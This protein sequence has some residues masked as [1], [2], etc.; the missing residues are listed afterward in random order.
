PRA[1]LLTLQVQPLA[2]EPHVLSLNLHHMITDGWSMNLLID[3]WL[4]GY[5]AL[6]AGKPMP[7]QPLPVQ[8]RDYEVW[9]RSWLEAG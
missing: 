5:D 7:F 6:L 8:Y 4:R 2:G 9:Q 1:P 3:E